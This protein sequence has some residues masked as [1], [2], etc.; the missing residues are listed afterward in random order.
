M[1]EAGMTNDEIDAELRAEAR[2]LEADPEA[3]KAR[4]LKVTQQF[5]PGRREIGGPSREP[6]LE[7]RYIAILR[8][9]AHERGWEVAPT[10]GREPVL[11]A[12]A[13]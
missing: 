11:F 8:A 10:T 1:L 7:P 2:R 13:R 6:Q 9:L 5:L 12:V 4:G 3:L